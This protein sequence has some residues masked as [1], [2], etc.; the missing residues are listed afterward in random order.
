[1]DN[2][3]KVAGKRSEDLYGG[4]DTHSRGV[5]T[6]QSI[7]K[8][9]ERADLHLKGRVRQFLYATGYSERARRKAQD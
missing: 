6:L 5:S 3:C 1:M 4:S 8:Q 2:A 7:D 9:R